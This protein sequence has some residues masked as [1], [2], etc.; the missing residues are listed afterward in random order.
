MEISQMPPRLVQHVSDIGKKI[1]LLRVKRRKS[2]GQNCYLIL[3][4][5]RSINKDLKGP[6]DFAEAPA[7][8]KL[9]FSQFLIDDFHAESLGKVFKVFQNLSGLHSAESHSDV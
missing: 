9:L 4:S 2:A 6:V 3:H 7:H 5:F 8:G 1:D